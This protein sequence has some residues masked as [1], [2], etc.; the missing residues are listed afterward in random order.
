GI[1]TFSRQF[2]VT[3]LPVNQRPT[4]ATIANPAA[5]LQ[6]AGTQ[7]V[8]INGI[9]SGPGDPTQVLSLTAPS[10]NTGL[11]PSV[12]VTYTSPQTSAAL[13]YTP[14]PNVS[15]TA[16]ITVTVTDNGGTANGGINT[17]SRSFTVTVTPVNQ[18]PTLDPIANPAAIAENTTGPQTI[19]LT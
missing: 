14:R 2:T 1:N 3:V 18:Q 8:V 15:G 6:N 17:I 12:A 9:G 4:L 7:S 10:G 11:I 16:V 5:V 19:N 13:T